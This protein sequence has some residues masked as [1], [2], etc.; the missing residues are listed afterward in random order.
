L[1]VTGNVTVSNIFT[2]SDGGEYFLLTNPTTKLTT[3]PDWF[4]EALTVGGGGGGTTGDVYYFNSSGTWTQT[5]A[6]AAAS[7]KGLLA[8]MTSGAAFDRGMLIRGY[9]RNTSWSWTVGATLYLSGTLGQI[10]Q[11]QPTGTGKIVR[12]V[13]YALSS[14]TIYFN[15]SQDW[16]ELA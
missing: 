5:D 15:P 6:D 3:N 8:I 12:V 13:G 14:N 1:N 4:G 16:V 9:W 2:V 10:T 11:T 7:S